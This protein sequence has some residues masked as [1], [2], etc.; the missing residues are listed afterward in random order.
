MV[1]EPTINSHTPDETIQLDG[2]MPIRKILP[3]GQH[4][5]EWWFNIFHPYARHANSRKFISLWD[6]CKQGII[7]VTNTHRLR[8]R[9]NEDQLIKLS[10][11]LKIPVSK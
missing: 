7:M 8:H 6:V 2:Y 10:T 4:M 11:D 9:G 1:L 3:V 5:K